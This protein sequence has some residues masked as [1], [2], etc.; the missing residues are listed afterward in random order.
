MKSIWYTSALV[1]SLLLTGC[2]HLRSVPAAS[3][4]AAHL[5]D[6]VNVGYGTQPRSK[7]TGSVASLSRNDIA[8]YHAP[9]VKELLNR[10]PGFSGRGFSLILVDGVQVT[11]SDLVGIDPNEVQ[12][13]SLL[14]DAG[15]T[16]I[17]GFRASM[18]AVLVITTQRVL[19][20]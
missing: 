17:Y 10:A 3:D 19:S 12:S 6:E 11:R 13:I 7:V 14:K 1:F 9:S 16:A 15:S 18:G 2:G 8:M 4:D 20:D 5:E